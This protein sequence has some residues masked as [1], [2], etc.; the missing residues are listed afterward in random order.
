MQW[1]PERVETPTRL[2]AEGLSARQIAEKLGGGV[3][4]NAVIGKAHRLNLQRGTEIPKKE[5]EP[6]PV[7]F[8]EPIFHH[9]SGDV[10]PWMCRW[11]TDEPGKYGL[12]ICGKTVQPGRHYCAEH[13]T[14][15]YLR[16]RRATAAA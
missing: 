4:R 14:A 15:H 7:I 10:E 8:E 11:P 2:W 9:P 6:E 16:R 3:T 13:C 1:S 12:H 5:P